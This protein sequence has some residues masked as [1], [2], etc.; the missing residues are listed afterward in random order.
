[1]SLRIENTDFKA[2]LEE[3]FANRIG[4]N[5]STVTVSLSLSSSSG[6]RL[7]SGS[8]QADFT[9][10]VDGSDTSADDTQFQMETFEQDTNSF[11]TSAKSVM[12]S[13]GIQSLSS[14]SVGS[15]STEPEPADT[16]DAFD[17]TTTAAGT[18]GTATGEEMLGDGST[19]LC[20][21][22]YPSFWLLLLALAKLG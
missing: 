13:K 3:A 10:E 12:E 16:P 2:G 22:C 17:T 8:I 21:S 11:L 5:A 19:S 15:V 14:S 20:V 1:M 9:V 4:V 6:R 7:Q 18:A